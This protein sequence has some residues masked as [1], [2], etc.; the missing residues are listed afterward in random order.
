MQI[1]DLWYP[2][3]A[4]QGLSFARARIEPQPHVWIHA[5]PHALRV[6][7]RDDAGQLLASADGLPRE[8]P[9]FPMTLLTRQDA[10][11]TRR[12]AFPQAA[13]LGSV[14]LLPG[15]EAGILTAWWNHPD[16]TEWRWSL[17]FYNRLG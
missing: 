3:A 5:A 17:E 14:V 8:G 7:V 11:I 6:E 15:G 10:S 9:Y 13:D 1:W 2:N 12:D 4:A 16:G